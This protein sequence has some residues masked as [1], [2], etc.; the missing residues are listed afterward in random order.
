M[1]SSRPESAFKWTRKSII[2]NLQTYRYEP[3][4][5]YLLRE[6]SRVLQS[7]YFLD[8]GANIG[9]YSLLIGS[10]GGCDRV[11]AYEPMPSAHRELV[12]NVY[13]NGL[14]DIVVCHPLAV[15]SRSGS[16][17]LDIL[18]EMAGGNALSSTAVHH[19]QVIR[20]EE[21]KTTTLDEMHDFSGCRATLKIDVE[22]HEYQVIK[23][24]EN[25]L[26]SNQ[27]LLQVELLDRSRTF[28]DVLDLLARLG[29]TWV[30]SAG[31][32]KYFS[33]DQNVSDRI[34]EAVERALDCFIGDFKKPLY[35]KSRC[36]PG[37]GFELS[38]RLLG[39]IPSFLRP[40]FRR[41]CKR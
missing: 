11:F 8:V 30:F 28:E 26:Q 4:Q 40:S 9:Y 7:E 38:P 24:A 39:M 14:E 25:L 36:L 18:G 1:F 19:S 5:P 17:S 15:S 31:P 3:V 13:R 29:F 35:V 12:K 41:K 6:F 27:I 10:E 22:G 34:F 20:T 37:I 33:N 16:S 21:V 23:G 2:R 32:D